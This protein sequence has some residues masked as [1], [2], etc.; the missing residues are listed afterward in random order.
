MGYKD[1]E[2]QRQLVENNIF[3]S[4]LPGTF[5]Q[6]A[7]QSDGKNQSKTIKNR[8]PEQKEEKIENPF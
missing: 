3:L 8:T 1:R 4:G 6:V 2:K 5:W 7:E